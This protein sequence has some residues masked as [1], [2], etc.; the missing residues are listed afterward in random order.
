MTFICQFVNMVY[1]TD[2][3]V[4]I[5]PFLHPWNKSHL[6][7][8]YDPFNVL[9]NLV[10]QYFVKVILHICFSVILAYNFLSFFLSFFGWCF[11]AFVWGLQ[12]FIIQHNSD[13]STG[14]SLL[15]HAFSTESWLNWTFVVQMWRVLGKR[16]C[17]GDSKKEAITLVVQIKWTSHMKF[18]KPTE[19]ACF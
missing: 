3:F 15:D 9:L 16:L 10:S 19:I 8:V 12:T 5:K 2:L 18:W 7:T 14:L 13:F 17:G 1:P 11:L 6:I 4:D